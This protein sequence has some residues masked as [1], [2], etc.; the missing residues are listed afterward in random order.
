M[1]P[2]S[3]WMRTE[4]EAY[5]VDRKSMMTEDKVGW[6]LL[7]CGNGTGG[8]TPIHQHAKLWSGQGDPEKSLAI[9]SDNSFCHGW[10]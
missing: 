4:G 3:F 2:G 1:N 7:L 6:L 10:I 9:D 8:S 5:R